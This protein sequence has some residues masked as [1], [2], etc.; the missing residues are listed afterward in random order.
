VIEA[1]AV[2]RD[3]VVLPGA[4]VRSGA[5]VVRAVLDDG[6]RI[7]RGAAVGAPDGAIALV[8]IR[9]EVG[10]EEVVAAGVRYPG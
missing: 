4:I 6:V 3:S 8:G 7:G 9:S 1:G 2:V 10:D 5:E